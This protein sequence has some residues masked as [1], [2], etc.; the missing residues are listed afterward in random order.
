MKKI[1][2]IIIGFM[3]LVV[4]VNVSAIDDNKTL[5]IK[6]NSGFLEINP[7]Y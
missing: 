7:L 3:A 6:I 1:I 2:Y 5:K 4:L